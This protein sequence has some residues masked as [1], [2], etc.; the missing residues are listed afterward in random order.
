MGSDKLNL[1]GSEKKALKNL[2]RN[3]FDFL[4][5]MRHWQ[6][7]CYLR[8]KY[9]KSSVTEVLAGILEKVFVSDMKLI[10][11]TDDEMDRPIKSLRAKIDRFRMQPD[12]LQELLKER[13]RELL[14][15]ADVFPEELDP[16]MEDIITR[17]RHA[18]APPKVQEGAAKQVYVPDRHIEE[19]TKKLRLK[20]KSK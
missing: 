10:T 14:M 3:G 6:C 4:F 13:M 20:R 12:K 16:E 2:I 18:Y 19:L 8:R 17:L 15:I 1:S 5:E 11:P 9:N 7:L